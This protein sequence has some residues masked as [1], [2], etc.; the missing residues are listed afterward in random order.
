VPSRLRTALFTA[1]ALVAFA[2]NSLLCRQA[3]GHASIDAASF[4]SIRLASGAVTLLLVTRSTG[5]G[6]IPMR[7]SWGSAAM[8][9]LYAVPFSFAYV[10]L[11]AGT[12]AL[13][14]FGSVQA[15]ML[16][17][18]LATG[19][20]PPVTQWVGLALAVCGLVYLVLPGLAAPSPARCALMLTAGIAW[21]IYSLRGRRA[22]APLAETAG[23]F[24]RAVPLAAAVSAVAASRAVWSIE[25]V[26][27]AILSGALAS[28][29]GYVAWYA[30]LSGL[31]ATRAATVQ[32]A[33]PM[34]AAAGG[35]AF[36]AE[37]I[38][39]RL[40]VSAALI[41]GGV[42]LALVRTERRDLPVR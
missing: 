7:G 23:N 6:S 22:V 32:L 42:A 38:T 18:A 9:F 14:L 2:A 20:R 35:V 28:G 13:I 24:V 39:V 25:G 19:E 21:G 10:G 34:L 12:G 30:A 11:G 36:L 8:L 16:A 17:A 37:R 31:T 26:L 33:V 41:L 5:R 3:L 1:S 4:S 40:I 29:L 27:L 15:T